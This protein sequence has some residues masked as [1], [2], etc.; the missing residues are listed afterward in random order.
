MRLLVLRQF[1]DLLANLFSWDRASSLGH[2]REENPLAIGRLL[3]TILS[4]FAFPIARS[5]AIREALAQI[6]AERGEICR[7][8][9]PAP[10]S[11]LR[12]AAT[13][14]QCGHRT[15]WIRFHA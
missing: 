9:L 8:P 4:H 2:E 12:L 14:V 15:A 5:F 10:S 13:H 1:A 7:D 6:I 11:T 3:L